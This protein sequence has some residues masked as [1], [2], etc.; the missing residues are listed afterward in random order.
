MHIITRLPHNKWP[1]EDMFLAL[2]FIDNFSEIHGVPLPGR[3]PNYQDSNVV[4][5]LTYLNL[6]CTKS[7]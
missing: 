4:S 3:I 2:G 6:M 5:L 1:Q 7:M